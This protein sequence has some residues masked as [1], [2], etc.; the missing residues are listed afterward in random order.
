[1]WISRKKWLARTELLASVTVM[2]ETLADSSDT[3]LKRLTPLLDEPLT[4]SDDE[5]SA[6][7]DAAFELKWSIEYVTER[8]AE[9]GVTL[10][11]G[12]WQDWPV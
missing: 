10:E 11:K 8:C 7:D 5:F 6:V 9:M 1:M 4:M 2:V 12:K 3:A